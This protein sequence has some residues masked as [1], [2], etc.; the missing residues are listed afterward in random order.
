MQKNISFSVFALLSFLLPSIIVY[1]N[2]G[3]FLGFAD[4]AEFALV[5]KIAGIA[6]AP[7]FPAYILAG[8]LWSAIVGLA[9]VNHITAMILFSI[10][11]TASATV[12]LFMTFDKILTY[13]YGDVS[14]FTRHLVSFVAC[15]SFF[16]G[17]TAWLWSS[18]VEVYTFQVLAFAMVIYGLTGNAISHNKKSIYIAAVG[19]A[20]GLANHHLTMIFFLP[21]T[22]WF[23][24][25][26]FQPKIISSTKNQKKVTTSKV[27][28]AAD[29]FRK[30]TIV[31]TILTVCFYGWMFIRASQPLPFKFGSP[32]SMQRLFYHL[33]GGAWLENTQQSVKGIVGLRFPYFMK[34]SFEQIFLFLP[35]LILGCIE[36]FRKRIPK[37]VYIAAGYYLLMLIY[38]L[39]IDQTADTDAYMLPSFFVLAI[40]IPFGMMKMIS[41]QRNLQYILPAFIIIQTVINFPK[42]DKRSF[43]VS[44]TLMQELDRSAPKGSVIL[45]AD[46][47]SVIQY[48]YFRIAENFRPDLVVLNY[49]L[50]FTHYR[51]LPELYPEFY[52]EIK[53]E[54]DRYIDLLGSAHPQ[55]IYNTGCSLDNPE[56]LQSWVTTIQKIKTYCSNKGVPFMNDPKAFVFLNQYQLMG[57][58]SLMSG[59]LVTTMNTGKGKDFLKLDYKWLNSP[60]LLSEP[61]ATDKM[62]D[63][64][65][66]LDFN[67]NYFHS[68]GNE[69]LGKEA[70]A[71]YERIKQLQ[72]KMKRNMPFVYR[73]K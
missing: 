49:D 70:D 60:L 56:L 24:T 61:S 69:V 15:C 8:K 29:S 35:F 39:R 68:T 3:F 33:A 53:P 28:F 46:W 17:V 67:R 5:S 20:F 45:F 18:N 66:A 10:V 64:E 40:C 43:N 71:S 25:S 31:T 19:A 38:Q 72:R 16:T 47:T 6:H 1:S 27:L 9:G 14:F 32:D 37:L 55:E 59:P 11:C 23:F 73:A 13:I 12:L 51:I 52:K 34:I 21:F 63:L 65:A 54:Y 22:L 42:T 30:F 57:N 36:L 41:W 48:Y 50:K 2:T 58:N 26:P 4:A 7:G 44:E 62:V